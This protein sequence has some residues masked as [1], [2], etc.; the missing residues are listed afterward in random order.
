MLNLHCYCVLFSD[1]NLLSDLIAVRLCVGVCENLKRVL[2]HISDT[3]L[4]LF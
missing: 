2:L 1:G 3:Y 4:E